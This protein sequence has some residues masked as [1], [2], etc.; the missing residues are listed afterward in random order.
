METSLIADLLGPHM[1]CLLF[2]LP[3]S[4]HYT[5]ARLD[6]IVGQLDPRRRNVVEFRHRSW[7]NEDVYDAFRKTGIIFCSCSGPR[8]PDELIKTA[9]EVYLRFHG[10]TNWYRH[11]YA[12]EL[13]VGGGGPDC[14]PARRGYTSTTTETRCHQERRYVFTFW[15]TF[16][17][18][19]EGST[20]PARAGPSSL[21]YAAGGITWASAA[22]AVAPAASSIAAMT[23][24]MAVWCTMCP[25]PGTEWKVLCPTS[26]CS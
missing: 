13:A 1:G 16:D 24:L 10:T 14:R 9:D 11:D 12:E 18:T 2:Q 8:L 22:P 19:N 25:E 21:C 5:A 7:W 4:F 20:A 23:S 17:T 26:R 15:A 6:S 3:P